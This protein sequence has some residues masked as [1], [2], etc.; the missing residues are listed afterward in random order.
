[1]LVSG[2]RPVGVSGSAAGDVR[3]VED[4]EGADG[5]WTGRNRI[6]DGIVMEVR[7]TT[8]LARGKRGGW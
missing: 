1:M 2:E 4:A 3:G 7:K 8:A 5:R 6:G